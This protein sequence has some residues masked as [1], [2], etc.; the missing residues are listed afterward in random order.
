MK[1]S[2]DILAAPPGLVAHLRE[3]FRLTDAFA[4]VFAAR[5]KNHPEQAELHLEPSLSRFVGLK[6]A[7]ALPAILETLL[8]ARQQRLPVLF[9]GDYD[10][11]GVSATFILYRL[12]QHLGIKAGYFLPSRFNEGYGLSRRIVEQAAELDYR[13]L[14]ALDCGTA[15][16]AEVKLAQELGLEVLVLDHHRA[17]GPVPDVPLINPALDEG[18]SPMCTAALAFSL[19]C[20]WLEAEGQP[21]TLAEQNFL[22]FAALGIIADVVPLTGDNFILAHF[23][24]E[25]IPASRNPGLQALLRVLKLQEQKFLTWRN[26][27]FSL[28]PCLNAAG[29]MAH[30]RHAMELFLTHDPGVAAERA[31]TVLKLNHDRKA[32][33]SRIFTEAMQQAELFPQANILVLYSS[34][35]NQGITGIVAAKV[36]EVY[37]RPTI[38]LSD[39]SSEEN[40][41]VGSG[42]APAG[43]DLFTTL[44]PVRE[45]FTQLGGHAKAV[46]GVLSRS[47]LGE[48]RDALATIELVRMPDADERTTY[49]AVLTPEDVTPAVVN[50]LRRAYPFGEGYPPP[51]VLMQDARVN[52]STLIGY[53]RTHLLLNVTGSTGTSQLR[54]IGFQ[55]SH[56]AERVEEGRSYDLG[57][58][59][60]LDNF[61][62]ELSVQLRLLEVRTT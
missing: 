3:D 9:Y 28:I 18:L 20:E 47:H 8:R 54:V 49:E 35:W 33:Q 29:R 25:K 43:C 58:E 51:R 61:G 34:E 17:A 60:D 16:P 15:N 21:R 38:I 12:A 4:R 23:G 44:Q 56:L 6:H 27:A 46:G 48:L 36:V 42:R 30:A 59:L 10:V 19:A 50:D 55:M 13:V 1:T 32:Q 41:I 14:L 37:G 57:V 2:E 11:D 40:T 22:E 45:L 5:F 24:M 52:R 7:P 62:G 39:S 26:L 31:L 53:D